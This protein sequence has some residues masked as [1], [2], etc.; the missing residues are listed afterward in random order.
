MNPFP[1]S[2]HTESANRWQAIACKGHNSWWRYLLGIV[3][4]LVFTLIVG[5][6]AALLFAV[7]VMT[8]QGVPSEE[9][10]GIGVTTFFTT[11]SVAGF[12][13]NNI[14]FLFGILALII[15]I[16]LFHNRSFFSLLGAS[17][18]LQWKPLL[19]A[20]G[21]WFAI[22]SS[23]TSFFYLIA[24]SEFELTFR[25]QSWLPLV[26]VTVPLTFLQVACEELFFRGYLLQGLGLVIRSK[27]VLSA[28]SAVPF[29]LV[30]FA[31]PEMQRGAGWMALYYFA[32]GLATCWITL[33][34]DRLEPALGFHLANN[35]F[36]I[37][38]VS[39]TDSVLPV[40]AIFTI[41]ADGSAVFSVLL[42]IAEAALFYGLLQKKLPWQRKQLSRE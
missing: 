42:F 24:P 16:P 15:I 35:Y 11:A 8:I 17:Q 13:G 18:R 39:S 26:L 10:L 31:N 40:P 29:A 7:L 27:V 14:P 37:L 3:I 41:E 21:L 12:I 4:F 28:I 2:H 33:V 30:H 32:F 9:I 34:R 38:V 36:G 20:F 23:V 6:I 1:S 5:S 22:I 19:E 25:W